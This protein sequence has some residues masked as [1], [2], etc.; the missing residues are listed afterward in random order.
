M[1]RVP[2]DSSRGLLVGVVLEPHEGDQ[3][4]GA[5]ASLSSVA[6]VECRAERPE[7]AGR[8]AALECELDRLED[9]EGREES[10]V[11]ERADDAELGAAFGRVGG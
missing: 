2:V 4:A 9:R 8:L 11:L 10:G 1:R 5:G 6:P 3:L 7:G